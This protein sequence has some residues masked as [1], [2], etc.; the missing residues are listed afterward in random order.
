M[1]KYLEMN[2][3]LYIGYIDFRKTFDSA[4][5]E[6]LWR[7]LRRLGYAEKLVKITES[8]MKKPSVRSGRAL[9]TLV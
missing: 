7:V 6:G 4:W 2:W 1:E 5:R 9:V 8:I 3:G